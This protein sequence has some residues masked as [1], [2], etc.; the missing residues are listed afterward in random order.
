M[1]V[2]HDLIPA[3]SNHVVSSTNGSAPRAARLR[4]RAKAERYWR[5]EK[6]GLYYCGGQGYG[7]N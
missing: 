1:T 4:V 7:D 6:F 3:L 2:H 5:E